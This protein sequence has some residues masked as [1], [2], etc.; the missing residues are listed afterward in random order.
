MLNDEAFQ[1][2]VL[3]ENVVNIIFDKKNTTPQ[4]ALYTPT[5]FVLTDQDC[6]K[7]KNLKYCK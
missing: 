1:K 5:D 3:C 4:V 2:N 7:L 6:N